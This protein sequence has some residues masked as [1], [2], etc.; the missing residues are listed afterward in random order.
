[1]NLYLNAL[2]IVTPLGQGKDQ[3]AAHLFAGSRDGLVMRDALLPDRPVRVGA[4]PGGLPEIPDAL[5]DLACRNNQL[6][7]ACL[8][9][10]EEEVAHIVRRHGAGRIGVVMGTSTSGLVEG[11]VA[12]ATQIETGAWPH[13][14]VYTR[15]ELG[16]TAM[17]VARAC[18]VRGPAYTISTACSS[19]GKVFAS[20]ARLIETGSAT[21]CWLVVL[22][23][24][25]A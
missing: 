9:E 4:V 6:A 24:C 17:F 23:H 1:M 13:G 12:L 5:G 16:N 2:G 20:A 19:S 14:Y 25:A 8:N 3:V 10:I 18:G 22:I 21:R 7:L 15:Q 11:E